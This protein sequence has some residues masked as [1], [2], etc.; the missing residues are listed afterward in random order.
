MFALENALSRHPH[1]DSGSLIIHSPHSLFLTSLLVV[2]CVVVV[3]TAHRSA[4]DQN[5]ILSL[6]H[7][8]RRRHL[9]KV[10]H[11]APPRGWRRRGGG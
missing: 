3:M 5:S 9:P 8:H 11:L 1:R 10:S 4:K 7:H 2:V 6:P